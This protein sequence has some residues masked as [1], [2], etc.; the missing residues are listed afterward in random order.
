[1]QSFN[2]QNKKVDVYKR[3]KRQWWRLS[4]GASSHIPIALNFCKRANFSAKA[5]LI[6]CLMLML[7]AA[8]SSLRG[9][10]LTLCMHVFFSCTPSL[11]PCFNSTRVLIISRPFCLQIWKFLRFNPVMPDGSTR[12]KLAAVLY[13][14]IHYPH[15]RGD[16]TQREAS[17]KAIL[18]EPFRW[19][20]GYHSDGMM[21]DKSSSLL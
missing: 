18:C 1:M 10:P 17:L 16:K 5:S 4:G 12:H 2:T 11:S 6:S 7:L 19:R 3:Q 8:G 14:S 15:V 21:I 13:K 20:F 9:N